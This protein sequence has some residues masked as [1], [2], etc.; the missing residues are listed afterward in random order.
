MHNSIMLIYSIIWKEWK[1]ALPVKLGKYKVIMLIY[2][3]ISDIGLHSNGLE[4]TIWGGGDK[5]ALV[6]LSF[7]HVTTKTWAHSWRFGFSRKQFRL[8]CC[9][10][11]L[12]KSLFENTRRN[13]FFKKK[14]IDQHAPNFFLE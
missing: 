11:P 4:N 10:P 8:K 2:C 13:P 7:T 5:W 12:V 3:R 6:D 14:Y 1:E 9:P